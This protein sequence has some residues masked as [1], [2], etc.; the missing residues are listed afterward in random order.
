MEQ[1]SPQFIDREK[2]EQIE[3]YQTWIGDVLKGEL[4]G[5]NDLVVLRSRFT[6]DAYDQRVA[7]DMGLDT[8]LLAEFI[9]EID[10][11]IKGRLL[12]TTEELLASVFHAKLFA[13]GIQTGEQV[14][15]VES[16]EIHE[17]R[18]VPVVDGKLYD[19]PV[20]D[21]LFDR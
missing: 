13:V 12:E 1:L 19:G 18:I 20:D 6:L 8:D 11:K 3:F 2:R 14:L 16:L 17:E 15:P 9:E 4:A 10:S 5:I 7:Y 21:V